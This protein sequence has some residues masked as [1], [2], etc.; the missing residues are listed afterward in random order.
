MADRRFNLKEF[1]RR[2]HYRVGPNKYGIQIKRDDAQNALTLEF[3]FKEWC[4]NSAINIEVSK[5]LPALRELY[6]GLP[7]NDK[8]VLIV[9]AGPSFYGSISMIKEAKHKGFKIVAVDRVFNDLKE[10]GIKPDITI[11]MDSQE[12]VCNL[13]DEKNIEE[14]DVFAINHTSSPK[15]FELLSKGKRYIYGTISP[16]GAIDD[17][18]YTRHGERILSIRSGIIVTCGAVDMC[19]W[20]GAGPIIT[21]GNDLCWKNLSDI[22]DYYIRCIPDT[23]IFPWMPPRPTVPGF[24]RA[25]HPLFFLANK[26]PDGVTVFDNIRFIDCSDGIVY[27]WE[28]MP[29]RKAIDEFLE[30]IE[31]EKKDYA[32]RASAY[33]RTG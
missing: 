9:A 8:P 5:T 12:C 31:D 2:G 24:I 25:T 27:G 4:Y 15:L 26:Y 6:D 10:N 1:K 32:N 19:I 28:K 30:V 11:T 7:W 21:I 22:P 23:R 13:F 20:M 29:L 17:V 16:F 18:L 33:A 3:F 14:D